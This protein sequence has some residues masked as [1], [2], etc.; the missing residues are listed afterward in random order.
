MTPGIKNI[1]VLS[2]V[3]SSYKSEIVY[4]KVSNS[5]TSKHLNINGRDSCMVYI[6]DEVVIYDAWN[7]L[8]MN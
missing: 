2:L 8:A 7:D 3:L 6:N 4:V 1:H 5:T